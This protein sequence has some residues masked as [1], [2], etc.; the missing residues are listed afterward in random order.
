MILSATEIPID[1]IRIT[2]SFVAIRAEL[3]N[4]EPRLSR[5]YSFSLHLN[6][7]YLD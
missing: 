3:T 4:V 5:P 1:N 2:S 6:S 7:V